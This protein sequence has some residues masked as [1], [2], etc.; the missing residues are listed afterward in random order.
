MM[1]CQTCGQQIV[2]ICLN[3]E[4]YLFGDEIEVR[5]SGAKVS[6]LL[7]ERQ[8]LRDKYK[9]LSEIAY[10]LKIGIY[11]TVSI[12]LAL[13]GYVIQLKRKIDPPS[14]PPISITIPPNQHVIA[15]EFSVEELWRDVNIRASIQ[16]IDCADNSLALLLLN[17][18]NYQRL[19]FR[20]DYQ[21]RYEKFGIEEFVFDGILDRD[22]YY[23]VFYNTSIS[24]PVSVNTRIDVQNK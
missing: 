18:D 3:C 4:G 7:E 1:K 6:A 9:K 23:I 11:I 21:P 12:G 22:R 5:T 20:L 14:P 19:L 16:C 13:L 24:H 10:N 17:E 2:N 8:K 15:T